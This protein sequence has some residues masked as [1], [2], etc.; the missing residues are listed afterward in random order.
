MQLRVSRRNALILS[1]AAPAAAVAGCSQSETKGKAGE[2]KDISAVEDLMREHG[3]LRRI[4]VVYRE[5]A[6][7]L[8]TSVATF[9]AGALAQAADLFRLFGEDYHERRLEEQHIFPTLQRLGGPAASLVPTLL[10]QHQRGRELTAYIRS[11]CAGGRVSASDATPLSTALETFA[12]MYE[13][14]TAFEDTIAFQA[15]EKGLS[16]KQLD[17]AGDEFEKIEREQFKGDGFDMAVAQI[18][19]IERRLGLSDLARYTAPPAPG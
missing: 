7:S 2:D 10:A 9:D 17:Q 5:A 6:R 19:D 8:P 16:G 15:W 14:H 3:V 12:R 4:L 1:A 13:A 18:G 11:R